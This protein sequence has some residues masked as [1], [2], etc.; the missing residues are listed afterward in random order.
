[1]TRRSPPARPVEQP[2]LQQL[3]SLMN[4]EGGSVFLPANTKLRLVDLD[5]A[6]DT[7]RAVDGLVLE[8]RHAVALVAEGLA[9]ARKVLFVGPPGTGKT[10]TA[11]A[12]AREL[13]VSGFAIS[14]HQIISQY[15]GATGAMLAK[16]FDYMA[17]TVAMTDRHLQTI[18]H[19]S[20]FVLD[21]L[22][23]I[24]SA[25]HDD[26]AAAREQNAILTTLLRLLDGFEGPGV[27]VATTN[28]ADAL[29]P[30]L[31]RRFE[32]EITFPPPTAAQRL[33]LARHHL[34]MGPSE[35]PELVLGPLGNKSHAEVVT[36][37][38]AERKRQ[39]L[40]A[41]VERASGTASAPVDATTSPPSRPRR[42]KATPAARAAPLEPVLT[43]P[44]PDDATTGPAPD[45]AMI[46]RRRAAIPDTRHPELPL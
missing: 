44:G 26:G 14:T 33:S 4:G 9:P 40:A 8:H 18:A 35:D 20:I 41:I 13:A 2:F 23:A 46:A 15:M 28:R 42:R 3:P 45:D 24:G 10:S 43:G 6:A 34:R 39:V 32:L 16:A 37:A 21:E 31:R 30:A 29:D 22:D 19:G 11:G 12:I 1:M 7:R 27:L 25:R 38:L 36:L 17:R 5:L